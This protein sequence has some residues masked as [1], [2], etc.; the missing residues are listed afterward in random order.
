LE[1]ALWASR[2]FRK[3]FRRVILAFATR[4][5]SVLVGCFF[6]CGVFLC[7]PVGG[8]IGSTGVGIVA[9]FS[10]GCVLIG[11]VGVGLLLGILNTASRSDR[12]DVEGG[13]FE[14]PFSFQHAY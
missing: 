6:G 2:C 7:S 9:P 10:I 13:P 1:F 8:I 5:A 14:P 12:I 4:T 3:E 11:P